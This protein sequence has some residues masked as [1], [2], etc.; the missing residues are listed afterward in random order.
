MKKRGKLKIGIVGCGAIG[1]SLAEE[2]YKGMRRDACLSALYDII[3]EKSR[4]L[5]RRLSGG[6]RLCSASLGGV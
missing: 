3:P 4:I 6:L 1:S 5:S 2:I